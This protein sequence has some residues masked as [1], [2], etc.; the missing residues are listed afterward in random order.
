MK[1]I[2]F[3]EWMKIKEMGGGAFGTVV[4]TPSSKDCH[5][6]DFQV[7]GSVCSEKKKKHKHKKRK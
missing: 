3:S 7:F 5:S 2:T 4:G 1:F 6:P